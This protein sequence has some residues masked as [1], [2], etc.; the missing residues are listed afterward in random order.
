MLMAYYRLHQSHTLNLPATSP[1]ST[2]R[3]DSA[4]DSIGCL[5]QSSPC[6]IGFAGK[7]ASGAVAPGST[8][9]VAFKLNGVDAQPQ[10]IQN[11]VSDAPVGGT[12][13]F[14]RKLYINST[15]GFE[16]VLGFGGGGANQ[17][18]ENK[19]AKCYANASPGHPLIFPTAIVGADFVSL[20]ENP[21][22]EDFV[23]ETTCAGIATTSNNACANNVA[24]GF[25]DSRA[26]TCGVS[27]LTCNAPGTACTGSRGA[28]TCQTTTQ[29]CICR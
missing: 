10:C 17:T 5:V 3:Q 16:N 2:C 24:A 12:Y 29:G 14:S 6:S 15:K 11:F 19:L 4:S 27:G 18:D 22:C 23:E 7:G 28:G 21:F 13:P 8:G 20:G 25:P 26:G 9:N 1:I